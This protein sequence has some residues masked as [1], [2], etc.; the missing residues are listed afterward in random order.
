MQE[1]IELRGKCKHTKGGNR[2]GVSTLK[3]KRNEIV[4]RSRILKKNRSVKKRGYT[5]KQ[6]GTRKRGKGQTLEKG[7]DWENCH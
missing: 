3:W 2:N 1:F 7:G 5:Q 4:T 6:T